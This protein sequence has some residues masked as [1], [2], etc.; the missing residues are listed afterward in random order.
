[1]VLPLPPLQNPFNWQLPPA[2]SVGSTT[3]S[4]V[5][6]KTTIF[7]QTVLTGIWSLNSNCSLIAF[8]PTNQNLPRLPLHFGIY[9]DVNQYVFIFTEIIGVLRKRK[10]AKKKKPSLRPCG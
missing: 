5:C 9:K 6:V 2:V 1:M 7:C 8:L 3:A 10:R 4:C